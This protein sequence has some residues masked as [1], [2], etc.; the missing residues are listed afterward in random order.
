[1]SYKIIYKICA[2]EKEANKH[3]KEVNGKAKN[4]YVY[5]SKQTGSWIVVLCDVGNREMADKAYNYFREKGLQIFLQ[6]VV[7]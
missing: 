5:H 4:P 3:L 6:K 2:T 1:M 7:E